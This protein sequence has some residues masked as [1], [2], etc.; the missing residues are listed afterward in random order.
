MWP[1]AGATFASQLPDGGAT[2]TATTSGAR[3]A[4]A[5]VLDAAGFFALAS[6]ASVAVVAKINPSR[7]LLLMEISRI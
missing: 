2:S 1:L 3:V 7:I 5:A 6:N 4:V